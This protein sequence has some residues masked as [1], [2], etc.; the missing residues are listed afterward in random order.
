MF[1]NVVYR[2]TIDGQGRLDATGTYRNSYFMETFAEFRRQIGA[3]HLSA[4]AAYTLLHA[5][6]EFD[7]SF[8]SLPGFAAQVASYT[9]GIDRQ[10]WI[11]GGKAVI[12]FNSPL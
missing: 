10:N 2:D 8:L 9:F 1:G 7:V 11:V 3:V 6:G 4:F 5:V 12:G